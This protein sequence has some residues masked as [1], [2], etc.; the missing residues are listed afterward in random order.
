VMKRLFRGVTV[1][2]RRW[3]GFQLETGIHGC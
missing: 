1:C 3:T 2:R